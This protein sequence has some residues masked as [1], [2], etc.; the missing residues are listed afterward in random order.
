M[1]GKTALR[2]ERVPPSPLAGEGY[3]GLAN[4]VSLAVVG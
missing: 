1:E 2:A 3:E 4:E